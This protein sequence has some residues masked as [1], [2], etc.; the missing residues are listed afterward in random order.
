MDELSVMVGAHRLYNK[1]PWRRQYQLAQIVE[2]KE[3]SNVTFVYDVM[4]LRLRRRIKFSK[5]V[6][7]ICIDEDVKRP[8]GTPC[9]V[10]GWGSTT[11]RTGMCTICQNHLQQILLS[12]SIRSFLF[13]VANS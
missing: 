11:T 1:E 10:S 2:H 9:V 13:L 4:L 6:R 3:F 5:K 8:P 7:P 12:K